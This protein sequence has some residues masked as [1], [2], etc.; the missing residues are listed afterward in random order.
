MST[1]ASVVIR[2]TLANRPAAGIAGRLFYDTTNSQLQRD[3]GSSWDAIEG[4][5][6]ATDHGAL[7]GL[8]DDDHPQ[9]ASNAE[10]DDHSARH[11]DGGADEI[12]IAGLAGVPASQRLHNFAA[13]AA[14]TV[15][16][17]S[18]DGYGVG[19][20]WYDVTNDR[21]YVCID[22]TSTAAIW[23]FIPNA[24]STINV[25]FYGGGAV[26]AVGAFVDLVF[27]FDLDWMSWKA[28]AKESGSIQWDIWVDSD[29]N[30]PPTNADTICASDPP[31][32]SSS[33]KGADAA[34]T[35]WTTGY[36]A[37]QIA[38]VQVEAA[39]TITQ[40]TLALKY[41]RKS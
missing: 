40:A 17:D 12:T 2:D 41:R 16:D 22:A 31:A 27:D 11:E 14:P 34:P 36:T 35:G 30:F 24:I 25:P 6:G 1:L 18:G 3:N 23:L 26:I 19:S 13:S 7:T 8:A 15:N 20:H 32:I 9:Y 10:F 37:G 28:Y 21:A 4:A 5:G 29:A 38:R 33:N 39:T